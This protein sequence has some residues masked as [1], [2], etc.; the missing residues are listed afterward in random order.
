MYNQNLHK[1]NETAAKY[2]DIISGIGALASVGS[3]IQ[4]ANETGNNDKLHSFLALGSAVGL[5]NIGRNAPRVKLIK[6]HPEYENLD[7]AHP[8]IRGSLYDTMEHVG[9]IGGSFAPALAYQAALHQ[10]RLK[11]YNKSIE[12]IGK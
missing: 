1:F 10:H 2:S 12:R 6:D 4:Y 9:Y 8:L 11:E 3:A 5:S 7:P